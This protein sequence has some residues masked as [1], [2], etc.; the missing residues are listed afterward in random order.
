MSTG[1]SDPT[2][3][4]ISEIRRLTR[5]NASLREAVREAARDEIIDAY[6]QG[7]MDVHQNYRPDRAPDFTEAAEDY[8]ALLEKK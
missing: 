7:A 1:N 8:Y 6:K 3:T 5:Q 4:M 2:A